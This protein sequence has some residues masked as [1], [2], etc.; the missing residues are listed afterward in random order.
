MP[1]VVGQ[2]RLA[3]EQSWQLQEKPPCSMSFWQLLISQGRTM[4]L[5]MGTRLTCILWSPHLVLIVGRPPNLRMFR[6]GCR[7]CLHFKIQTSSISALLNCVLS[8]TSDP[9]EPRF[10]LISY[11][12]TIS[13]ALVRFRS[14][15]N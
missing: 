9:N 3:N 11:C 6:I 2:M 5:I 8:F 15:V 14:L 7:R 4:Y 1:S 12:F 13:S 10:S